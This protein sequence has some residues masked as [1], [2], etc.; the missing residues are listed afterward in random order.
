MDVKKSI[1][2]IIGRH[3]DKRQNLKILEAGC[4]SAI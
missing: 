4:G 3:F 2:D 1:K